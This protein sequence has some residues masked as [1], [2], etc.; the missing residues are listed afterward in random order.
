MSDESSRSIRGDDARDAHEVVKA[1]SGKITRA[2]TEVVW[3][4]WTALGGMASAKRRAR[5]LVDPEALVLISLT[6]A[7]S[8]PRLQDVVGD[9]TARNSDLLSVQRMRNLADRYPAAT[10]ERLGGLARIALEEGKDHRWQPL[11]SD[12]TLEFAR[13]RGKRRAIRFPPLES[14]ALVARFRLF[15]GVGIKA[16]LFS[17]LLSTDEA[18]AATVATIASATGYTVPAV[19]KAANGLAEARFIL[20]IVD[21]NEIT[22]AR[23]HY[24]VPRAGWSHV[25]GVEQIP[26]WRGWNERFVFVAAFLDWAA[27]VAERPLTTYVLDSAGRDLIEAH[28]NAFRWHRVWQWDSSQPTGSNEGML[29]SAIDALC[30]WMLR[31]V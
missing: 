18:A 15:L 22:D 25:L 1:L 27:S 17:F 3:R 9:W 23:V 29:A 8:E 26:K 31:E 4:Q 11:V 20:S 16:D 13:R 12:T 21:S 24:Q 7:E 5:S 2:T 14:A 6:L 10:Q 19:R 28:S 30:A